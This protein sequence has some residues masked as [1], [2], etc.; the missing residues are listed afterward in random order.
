MAVVLDINILCNKMLDLTKS[1]LLLAKH[2]VSI[3][4]IN[5]I[6]NW[7][8]ENEK[9]IEDSKQITN[10]LDMQQITIIKLKKP[11]I[12]DIGI[13]IEKIENQFLYTLWINTEGYTM[14]DCEKITKDNS[15]FYKKIVLSILELNRLIEDSFEVVGIGLETD[16]YYEKDVMDIIRK[17]KNMM[18]WM[19]NKQDEVNI[20]LEEFKIDAIEGVYVLQ[21]M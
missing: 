10:I 16:F 20:Q 7:M 9:E 17:S 2:N 3:E 1:E 8:W 15:E 12:K 19:L 11:S 21:R 13:Y 18:I 4:S 14:L 5:S 6:D